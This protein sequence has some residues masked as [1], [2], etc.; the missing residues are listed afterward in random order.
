MQSL[1]YNPRATASLGGSE[2]FSKHNN[3]IPDAKQWLMTQRAYTLHRPARRRI[4]EYRSY[5]TP[6]YGY[7]LQADLC[8]MGNYIKGNRQYRYILTVIDIFTRYAWA[9]PLKRKTG[10]DIVEAFRKHIFSDHALPPPLP[11]YLQVDMGTEFYNRH[12]QN[13]LLTRGRKTKLYHKNGW[14]YCRICCS[15]ITTHHIP[16]YLVKHSL[17]RRLE[18]PRVGGPYGVHEIC[19]IKFQQKLLN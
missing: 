3:N 10:M 2:A 17:L 6:F 18:K 1:Y 13:F 5:R 8:D 15:L 16:V 4:P 12:F 14:I 11:L 9:V 19:F 7:Q